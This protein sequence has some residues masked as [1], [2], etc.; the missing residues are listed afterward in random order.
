MTKDNDI[1]TNVHEST[2]E[3]AFGSTSHEFTMC[4]WCLENGCANPI[5]QS[6]CGTMMHEVFDCEDVK[7]KCKNPTFGCDC[8]NIHPRAQLYFCGHCLRNR[9]EG[10]E[11]IDTALNN[12]ETW[13]KKFI[14]DK[15]GDATTKLAK[16]C[17]KC[18]VDLDICICGL[19]HIFVDVPK[20][21]R[22]MVEK[23]FKLRFGRNDWR[24]DKIGVM[25]ARTE[26]YLSKKEV[27]SLP[28]EKV[29]AL[30]GCGRR[31]APDTPYIILMS[32]IMMEVEKQAADVDF[33]PPHHDSWMKHDKNDK[34]YFH[35]YLRR[36]PFGSASETRLVTR[37]I[38]CMADYYPKMLNLL[39]TFDKEEYENIDDMLVVWLKRKDNMRHN[40]K[41]QGYIITGSQYLAGEVLHGCIDVGDV[42]GFYRIVNQKYNPLFTLPEKI[43]SSLPKEFAKR[44]AMLSCKEGSF[45]CVEKFCSLIASE[46]NGVNKFNPTTISTEALLERMKNPKNSMAWRENTRKYIQTAE[47][48][49]FDYCDLRDSVHSMSTFDVVFRVLAKHEDFDIVKAA[50]AVV[51]GVPKELRDMLDMII[52]NDL[53]RFVQNKERS[54]DCPPKLLQCLEIYKS[55]VGSFPDHL[56]DFWTSRAIPITM[57]QYLMSIGHVP[58]DYM[59]M[60]V[61]REYKNARMLPWSKITDKEHQF[62]EI[63]LANSRSDSRILWWT[64]FM[65]LEIVNVPEERAVLRRL[66]R[67]YDFYNNDSNSNEVYITSKNDGITGELRDL[68]TSVDLLSMPL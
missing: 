11:F 60:S 57:I 20:D 49:K 37:A 66:S 29:T 33:G 26:R 53:K 50:K 54:I 1:T 48:V 46:S 21:E 32:N 22:L 36:L 2:G 40:R 35:T 5:A 44:L 62:R 31:D 43:Y 63:K 28:T 58:C 14:C 4:E 56:S 52:R 61:A 19:P 6:Q 38:L 41:I 7:K 13:S 8:P 25:G 55:A 67:K 59:I 18:A 68:I 15:C 10:E 12:M 34:P 9:K 64:V 16:Y 51:E 23:Y 47:S 30:A 39:S 45:E 42:K 27:A 3:L 17:V 65:L 24:S